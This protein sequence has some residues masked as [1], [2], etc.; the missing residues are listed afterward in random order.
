M[1]VVVVE[2]VT[3][4]IVVPPAVTSAPGKNVSPVLT[5]IS[6]NAPVPSPPVPD[7]SVYGPATIFEPDC[8]IMEVKGVPVNKIPLLLLVVTVTSAPDPAPVSVT[9]GTFV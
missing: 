3:P 5:V 2:G 6:H 7:T 4:V 1:F 9:N 8:T